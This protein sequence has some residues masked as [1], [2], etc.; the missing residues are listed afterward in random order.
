MS[1]GACHAR[2]PPVEGRSDG[3]DPTGRRQV[4]C[5]ADDELTGGEVGDLGALPPGGHPEGDAQEDALAAET[6]G[7]ALLAVETVEHGDDRRLR[8]DEGGEVVERLVQ[9]VVLD[10]D[11]GEIERGGP[12][13]VRVEHRCVQ[14]SPVDSHTGGAEALCALTRGDEMGLRAPFDEVRRV[15]RSHG[16]GAHDS[17]GGDGGAHGGRV[18]RA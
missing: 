12:S 10:R 13:I 9:V 3:V 16:S 11:D 17:D 14:G 7:D 8:P 15:H 4:G 1:S 2:P 6:V 18:C 5:G